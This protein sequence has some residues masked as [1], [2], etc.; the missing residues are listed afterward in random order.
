MLLQIEYV[1]FI[2]VVSSLFL[3][4]AGAPATAAPI[5]AGRGLLSEAHK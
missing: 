2:R 3:L 4:A 1:T 5:E